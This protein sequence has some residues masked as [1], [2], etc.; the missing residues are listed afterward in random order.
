MKYYRTCPQIEEEVRRKFVKSKPVE[1]LLQLMNDCFDTM[2]NHE[3]NA[4]NS[5]M[6]RFTS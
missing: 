6:K 3:E 4:E 1:E 5:V 2:K